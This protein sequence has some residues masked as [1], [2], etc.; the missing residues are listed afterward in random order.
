LAFAAGF[1]TGAAWDFAAEG[2]GAGLMSG[3]NGGS[4]LAGF[5]AAPA[6]A[7]AFPAGLAAVFL[8]KLPEGRP[9]RSSIRST[10]SPSEISSGDVDF[11]MVALTL[12]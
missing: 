4:L 7:G 8:P 2:R 10:A 1:L 9:S 5:F 12:P 6:L 11:G 3:L